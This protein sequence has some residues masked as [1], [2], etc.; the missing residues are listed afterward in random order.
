MYCFRSICP[1]RM[2]TMFSLSRSGRDFTMTN[3]PGRDN[4]SNTPSL[5]TPSYHTMAPKSRV[6]GFL[7]Y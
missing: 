5:I 4:D 7:E 1:G 6:G 2:R 3:N